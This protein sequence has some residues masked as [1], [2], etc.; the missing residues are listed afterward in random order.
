MFF[1]PAYLLSQEGKPTVKI[2][3]KAKDRKPRNGY[4]DESGFNLNPKGVSP[5]CKRRNMEEEIKDRDTLLSQ[6]DTCQENENWSGAIRCYTR[7]IVKY[8]DP[9]FI[10]L[11]TYKK[12]LD[13][14]RNSHDTFSLS[15]EDEKFILDMLI[16]P[17]DFENQF[18]LANKILLEGYHELSWATFSIALK[19]SGIWFT[20]HPEPYQALRALWGIAGFSDYLE[21]Y[22]LLEQCVTRMVK[23][24]GTLSLQ[25]QNRY[26]QEKIEQVRL[27]SDRWIEKI[28]LHQG[29]TDR[30]TMIH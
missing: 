28:H 15:A 19:N 13:V 6:G 21:R 23:L 12:L 3:R 10:S 16:S 8:P 5:S 18:L 25:P 1:L 29:T 17:T 26:R 11:K 24:V 2:G 30:E 14:Y 22:D 27:Q 20:K 7:Y 9:V 4:T